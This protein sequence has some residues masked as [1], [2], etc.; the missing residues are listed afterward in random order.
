MAVLQESWV[1]GNRMERGAGV[2]DKPVAR[3]VPF[4]YPFTADENLPVGHRRRISTRV[5]AGLTCRVPVP[6]RQ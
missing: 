6:V 3:A 1:G 4:P 2:R 5:T